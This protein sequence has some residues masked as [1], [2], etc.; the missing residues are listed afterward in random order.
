MAVTEAD[1]AELARWRLGGRPVTERLAGRPDP[2]SAR[3]MLV[4][5][6]D[7]PGRGGALGRALAAYLG[8]DLDAIYAAHYP[9]KAAKL[10]AECRARGDDPHAR[11]LE[12]ALVALMYCANCGRPLTDPESVERG[13]GPDC[14]PRIDPRWRAAIIARM[15]PDTALF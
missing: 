6:L 15:A 10:A 7:R 8:D 3:A 9:R 12:H 13:I 11:A 1:Q 2:E 5:V 4:R 14:W